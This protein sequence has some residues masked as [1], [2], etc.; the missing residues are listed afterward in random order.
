M[1]LCMQVLCKGAT[2]F[3]LSSRFNG[4]HLQEKE[5]WN[6]NVHLLGTLLMLVWM[7]LWWVKM[8][9]KIFLV[10]YKRGS[11]IPKVFGLIFPVSNKIGVR[12][13]KFPF[14]ILAY[15]TKHLT[16]LTSI[17]LPAEI[18]WGSIRWLPREVQR[19][20]WSEL[21]S[22]MTTIN[23]VAREDFSRNINVVSLHSVLGSY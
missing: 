6:K 12:I 10:W 8:A 18:V 2:Q 13:R 1:F 20:S 5:I 22:M 7:C 21:V 23:T 3:S 16:K 11:G 9:V 19:T 17:H 14:L 4:R 15:L